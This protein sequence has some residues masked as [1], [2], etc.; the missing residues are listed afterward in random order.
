MAE[1]NARIEARDARIAELQ[2][3]ISKLT[4]LASQTS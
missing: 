2:A 1:A 3:E 4:G